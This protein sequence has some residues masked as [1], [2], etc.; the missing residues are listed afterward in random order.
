MNGEEEKYVAWNGCML[1]ERPSSKT[2][3]MYH[4]C[5]IFLAVSGFGCCN[6][7]EIWKYVAWL[8]H[9]VRTQK[10]SVVSSGSGRSFIRFS[11]MITGRHGWGMACLFVPSIDMI[12]MANVLPVLWVRVDPYRTGE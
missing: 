3:V 2:R 11:C 1:L 10:Q 4:H 8:H 12:I 7:C 5:C 6:V 9:L